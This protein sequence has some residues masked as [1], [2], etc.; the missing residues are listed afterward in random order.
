MI[1]K[2]IQNQND[3]N[4]T[5]LD[6]KIKENGKK[7]KIFD[8]IFNSIT[9]LFSL[10]CVVILFA[11]ITYIAST[12]GEYF[13]GE[14][15]TS[16]Y[17]QQSVTLKTS[18]SFEMPENPNYGDLKFED[19]TYYSTKWGIGL[20]NGHDV[21]KN[22][23][24]FIT[25]ISKESPFNYLINAKDNSIYTVPA[26]MYISNI[27][28]E[29]S[30]NMYVTA[31][32]SDG[33]ELMVSTLDQGIKIIDS[34]FKTLGGGIRGSL[35]TTLTLIGFTLLFSLPIGIG[36]AVY[37]GYYAKDN[38]VTKIIRTFVD[39][40]SGIPS[41]IY[42]LVGA[43]VFIPFVSSISGT[44][45]GNIFTGALTLTIILLPTIIK[46]V[47]ESIKTIPQS[48]TSASLA[49]GATEKQTIFKIIIPNSIE[50]ILNSI[51]LSI[52]RIIGESAALVFAMGT[53]IGDN[54]SL[55]QANTSLAVHIW[56]ILAGEHP[57]YGQ[58]CAISILI[59]IIVLVLSLTSK[60]ISYYFKKKKTR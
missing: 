18:S 39:M 17:N 44:N 49:L 26:D 35:L 38:K 48:M 7:R 54:P 40:A 55:T 52:G 15:L 21:N 30:D 10:L 3:S 16:N 37:L 23:V 1:N 47:E 8:G 57:Q 9:G 43:A 5:S 11:V 60:G 24:I 4:L 53:I 12:G 27:T 28:V 14:L 33:I 2:D 29:T 25:E 56:L 59:L 6:I 22:E 46:T 19:D 34:D 36:G 42:G 51:I 31:F 41:I 50:G 13:S 58:A 20:K 45:G 32:S